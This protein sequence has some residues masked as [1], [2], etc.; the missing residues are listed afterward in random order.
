MAADVGRP[1]KRR[2]SCFVS[3]DAVARHGGQ[4]FW[5]DEM[6]PFSESIALWGIWE[7][8]SGLPDGWLTP[9][10]SATP[11]PRFRYTCDPGL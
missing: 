4:D 2:P 10:K 3:G 11:I 8:L 9:G 7:P 6:I 5:I 1:G